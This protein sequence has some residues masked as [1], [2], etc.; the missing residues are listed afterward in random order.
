MKRFLT[1]ILLV[2]VLGGG[3]YAF[4]LYRS[5]QQRAATLA[6]LQTEPAGRGD[7]VATVGA[8]GVVRSSQ[9][10]V[11]V[12]QTSGTVGE[13]GVLAG[14]AVEA[15]DLLAAIRQT[16]LPQNV[17]LAQADLVSAQQALEDLQNSVLQEAQALIAVEEARQAL[18]DALNPELQQALALQAIADAEKAVEDAGTRL[19]IIQ[20]PAGQAAIDAQK[21]QV[22][23]AQD[24]LDRAR[25]LFEPYADKPEDNLIRANLQANL[26]AAQQNYDAAV[27]TL[28]GLL[29]TGNPFDIAQAEAALATAQAQLLQAQRDYEQVK[30]GP[31]PAQIALLDAQLADAE[32]YY[33]NILAGPDP[34]DLAAAQARVAAAQATLDSAFITAPF[35][36][37]ISEITAKPGD[38]VTAGSVA[39]RLDDLSHLFVDVEVSE[40]DINRIEVG[41]ETVLT[42]DAVLAREYHGVVTEVALVGTTVQGVVSFKVTVELLDADEDVRPGMTAGV[43]LVISQLADVLLVPNRAVRV[44][45]GERV[46]YILDPATGL[47]SPVNVLLGASSENYSEVAG[48][49]LEEGDTIV[50]NPPTDFSGF[51]QGGPP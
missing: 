26:S 44:L 43:N 6:G 20:T 24:A 5:D 4:G 8:T 39:F 37:V 45:E 13:V 41:Q 1:F 22:I 49:G 18:D 50:L 51:F 14:D 29:S 38:L 12:W 33:A 36:G 11:L 15:G 31:S 47:P 42:F 7:L 16:T 25:Q 27:R 40:V 34:D 17:I 10:A 21:A 28:N 19:R 48:G 35:S 32:E 3:L 2:I 9:G 23:L 30:D 46:V